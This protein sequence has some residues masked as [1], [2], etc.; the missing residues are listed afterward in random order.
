MK[1]LWYVNIVM[2]EAAKLLNCK[3][4]N[5]G[6]WL[7]GAAQ[8]LRNT[9]VQL[10]IMTVTNLVKEPKIADSG[11]ITYILIPLKQ[12]EA[13]FAEIIQKLRPD[14]VHIFGT[15]YQYNTRLL[16]LCKSMQIKHVI[17]LQGIMSECAKHYDDGLPNKFQRVNPLIKW[18]R[19]VY[20]ADSIALEK[21]RFEE[22]GRRETAA[23]QSAD[24]V[25]GRTEWDKRVALAV[26]PALTYFHVNENLRDAFYT[27]DCWEYKNCIPHTIFISQSFYPIK[28][29]HMLLKAM[30]KLIERYP[31][32]Q[33]VVGGQRP[34]SLNHKLLDYW[35]DFFFEYQKYTKKLVKKYGL[36]P[37]V[38]YTGTLTADQMKEQYLKSNLF[39]SCS[40]IENSPNSVAEAMI[41]GVPV[42]ASN[43]GGTASMLV[44]RRE[45]LLYDFYDVDAMITAISAMFDDPNLSKEM[46]V[47]AR[48]HAQETHDRE[49]N[50]DALLWVYKS[51]ING[52]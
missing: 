52:Q 35:V 14:L 45:G 16:H 8:G 4:G 37:Y 20:Y 51:L 1:V 22:Q 41:L 9:D 33:I 2:P 3:T 27:E 39:L 12:Y 7:T 5:T 50:T 29:F 34:Y 31:D 48:G 13:D 19:T 10:S 49:K 26:N 17:S 36:Q 42:V 6:G 38:H 44:D 43:V 21:K 18:M 15:E 28:G 47:C 40:T 25:I 30:P 46:S 32:I 24:A 11:D 23:F